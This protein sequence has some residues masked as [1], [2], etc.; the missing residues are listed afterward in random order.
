LRHRVARANVAGTGPAPPLDARCSYIHVSGDGN[1]AFA[2]LSSAN[3]ITRVR[4]S[5]H[6]VDTFATDVGPDND[7]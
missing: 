2:T 7:E 3:L 1:F 4:L 5:D 6:H